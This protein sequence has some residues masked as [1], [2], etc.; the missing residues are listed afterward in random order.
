MSAFSRRSFISASA[1]VGLSSVSYTRVA[2]AA[3]N[4]RQPVVGFIDA[5]DVQRIS[6]EALVE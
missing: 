6:A 1:A 2:Q 4:G 5:E 3:A